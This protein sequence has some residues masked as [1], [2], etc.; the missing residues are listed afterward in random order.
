MFSI[1]KDKF[2]T[3]LNDINK[4]CNYVNVK[5]KAFIDIQK[6]NELLAKIDLNKYACDYVQNRFIAIRPRNLP[7]TYIRPPSFSS[8]PGN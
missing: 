7:F 3:I 5:D 6:F 2:F 1:N 8:T 4:T